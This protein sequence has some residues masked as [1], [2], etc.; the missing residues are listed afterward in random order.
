MKKKKSLDQKLTSR[1]L[2][3]KVATETREKKFWVQLEEL[4]LSHTVPEVFS[5][6]VGT[7]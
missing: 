2:Q 6:L 1:Q 7:I 4:K 5:D 3:R